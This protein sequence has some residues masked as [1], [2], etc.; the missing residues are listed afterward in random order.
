MIQI[1]NKNLGGRF[2]LRL[3]NLL[4]LYLLT[5]STYGFGQ[6]IE[7]DSISTT[8]SI[9]YSDVEFSFFMM[10]FNYTNNKIKTKGRASDIVIPAYITDFTFLHKSGFQTGL[11][12]TNYSDADTL[13]YDL[14]FL[15]GYQKS[16]YK[17]LFDIDASYIYHYFKGEYN[18][19]GLNYNHVLNLSAGFTY[20]M[21][22]LYS[23]GFFLLD[24]ENYF[25]DAGAT[26]NVDFEDLFF[27]ND[28]L[29]IMPSVSFNFGTDHYLYDIYE[30]YIN[31]VLI[32]YLRF[33]GY[34]TFNISTEEIIKRHLENQDVSTNTFSYQGVDFLVP[35]TFGIGGV[36]ATFSWM[37]YIPS[38]KLDVFGMKD[39][40]GYIIS[41]SFIF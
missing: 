33:K 25:T 38:E 17:D 9:D 28:Y 22:Y 37:Y 14:D 11:M 13:S 20:K 31:N 40:T 6:I 30:P 19:E 5:T 10:D 18:Y 32:P 1:T 24:N 35:V 27:K 7:A 21:I 39:Q 3:F 23:N 16:F 34:Q 26:I 2:Y 12:I 15:L 36:S 8:D 4:L 29:Y 41:L